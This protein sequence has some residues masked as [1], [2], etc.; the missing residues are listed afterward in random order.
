MVGRP[1]TAVR[2]IALLGQFFTIDAERPSD[3]ETNC[4]RIAQVGQPASGGAAKAASSWFLFTPLSDMK[5]SRNA[6][7]P[8]ELI[9]DSTL[10]LDQEDRM[11]SV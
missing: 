11:E 3:E 8:E 9:N 7:S 4:M 10:P 1:A 5:L 2:L 6:R